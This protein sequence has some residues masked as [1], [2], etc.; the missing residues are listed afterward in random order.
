[1]EPDTNIRLGAY[2]LRQV[3]DRFNDNPVLATAAYNAG[4]HRVSKWFPE[5]GTVDA[6]IWVENMPFHETR[7]YVRRVMAYSVFDDQR[8][9]KG[10]TRL[11]ERMPIISNSTPKDPL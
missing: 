6:D 8:L 11:N 5:S 3:L 10:I 4:P 9:D 7:Q 1:M 2:Y